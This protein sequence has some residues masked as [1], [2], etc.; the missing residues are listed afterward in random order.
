MLPF[1]LTLLG[2]ILW[3]FSWLYCN[4]HRI[5]FAD[6]TMCRGLVSMSLSY[7]VCSSQ[8]DADWLAYRGN[9]GMLTVRSVIM[10]LQSFTTGLAQFILPLPIVHTI[11]CSGTIFVF[12]FDYALNGIA[13]GKQQ[14]LGM[15]IGLAGV[16]LTSNG[17]LIM[18]YV[19]PLYEEHS[20]YQNYLVTDP[21]MVSLFTLFYC[22]TT[23]LW[24]YATVLTKMAKANTFQINFMLGFAFLF[25]G[26]LAKPYMSNFGYHWPSFPEIAYTIVFTAIPTYIVQLLGITAMNMTKQTGL[27]NLVN[28]AMIGV[29]YFISLVRYGETLNPVSTIG[30]VLVVVGLTKA[31][32]NK[33]QL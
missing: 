4:E 28:F 31:V 5:S 16:L 17:K 21:M 32:L 6:S 8:K 2:S 33:Q 10:C 12:V 9:L 13:I 23:L 7:A 20:S 30:V 18:S 19:S 14:L 1:V 25:L 26:N 27:L 22:L 15:F 29:S 24:A 3:P 11:A